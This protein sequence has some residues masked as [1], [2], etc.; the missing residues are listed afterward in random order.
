[1]FSRE[2]S[3]NIKIL[4]FLILSGFF[5]YSASL[6]FPFFV[7]DDVFH[8]KENQFISAFSVPDLTLPWLNSKIPLV[9]NYWQVMAAFFGVDSPV[10]YR[11][12][13]I[14][15]HGVNAYLIFLISNL[16]IDS[17]IFKMFKKNSHQKVICSLCSVF[18]L[19]HP[20]HVES[21][22]WVSSVKGI[23]A[24]QF[25]LLAVYFFIRRKKEY[26]LLYSNIF[27]ILSFFIKPVAL[28]LVIVFLLLDKFIFQLTLK[29][30]YTR[31]IHLLVA[32]V[33]YMYFFVS[34]DLLKSDS[35]SISDRLKII[36]DS[37]LFY[38]S[39]S[40][41]YFGYHFNNARSPSI[42]LDEASSYIYF[43]ISSLLLFLFPMLLILKEK[44]RYLG[45]MIFIF[46]LML[47]VN[48][49]VVNYNFQNLSTVADRYLYAPLVVVSLMLLLAL[50]KFWYLKK[51]R[52][53]SFSVM[54]FYF[55]FSC[56][57][58]SL[59]QK[60]STIINTSVILDDNYL[61]VKRPLIESYI[62]EKD[63]KSAYDVFMEIKRTSTEPLS[64]GLK[65]RFIDILRYNNMTD[66][67]HE[68][69]KRIKF[70]TPQLADIIKMKFARYSL[71]LNDNLLANY[72]L[73]SVSEIGKTKEGFNI[74]NKAFLA[75][76][77]KRIAYNFSSLGLFYMKKGDYLRA[78]KFYINQKKYSLSEVD[79][80][81][82][83]DKLEDLKKLIKK[84]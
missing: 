60:S 11:F 74:L 76:F 48:T 16:L 27:L 23:L 79:R 38:I 65:I 5:L 67:L 46:Y 2:V 14:L 26:D 34:E 78:R 41:S 29:E 45:G 4:V 80:Q 40:L 8:I 10:P 32:S 36:V 82:A 31:Y 33:I 61:L 69:L 84:N 59:W 12:M 53:F 55:C 7:F 71:E 62:A 1:M 81:E 24:T 66:N 57:N 77:Y 18:F 6:Y 54:I 43:A 52:I 21:I 51:I 28:P 3:F 83:I 56:F 13:N 25:S 63:Y 70:L 37:L 19:V 50:S 73:E 30:I 9:Y 20:A 49:G 75:K 42:I 47:L 35:I 17:E 72:F 58:I 64:L 44:L 22:V 68:E 15:F 39:Q